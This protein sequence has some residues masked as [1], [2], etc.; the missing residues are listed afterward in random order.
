[1]GHSTEPSGDRALSL[2]RPPQPAEGGTSQ[3]ATFRPRV[4]WGPRHCR[5]ILAVWLLGLCPTGCLS[6]ETD[7]PERAQ[8]SSSL[9]AGEPDTSDLAV[10]SLV[11]VSDPRTSR[12][13]G[14][15]ISERVVITAA[16]CEAH[17]DPTAYQAFFGSDLDAGGHL[18]DILDGIGHPSYEN[19]AEADLALLLLAEPAP[20]TVRLVDEPLIAAPT[21]VALR[22][23]GFGMT[24]PDAWDGDRK[25]EGWTETTAVE[26]TFVTLGAAPSLPCSGDSGGPAFIAT[27]AGEALAAVVSRGDA[28]CNSY[29]KATRVDPYVSTF[30]QPYVEASAPGSA[31]DGQTCLYDEQCVGGLCLEA[32]DEPLLV[33]CS[34]PCSSGAACPTDMTCQA[35]QC[36]YPLPSP[37]AFGSVCAESADCLRGE[38]LDQ[39][40]ICSHRCVTGT[41]DCP[42]GYTCRH[43]GGIDF[44]CVPEAPPEEDGGCA[45]AHRTATHIDGVLMFWAFLLAASRRRAASRPPDCSR[46]GWH[47][48]PS[49]ALA[50]TQSTEGQARSTLR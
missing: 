14:T 49:K 12:C 8:V 44:F 2:L 32:D 40:A 6:F 33:F 17:L 3:P 5:H 16:H 48:D 34:R 15:A 42:G 20:A 21:P 29:G 37:G 13:T 39:Q 19:T 50:P 1:M 27:S 9:S 47:P 26:P 10:V 7:V 46:S 38:C 35:G 45:M 43:L 18:V 24:A 30:I 4:H 31:S 28:D 41:D 25:R 36:R 22:L 11:R 23:V